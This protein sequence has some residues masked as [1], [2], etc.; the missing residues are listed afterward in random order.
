[1]KNNVIPLF[2]TPFGIYQLDVDL[3]RIYSSLSKFKTSP[4]Y[5][6]SGSKSSF[7]RDVSILYE[8]DFFH[9]FAKIQLA[10]EEYAKIVSL[11][12]I[13][14]T[15]SWYNEMSIGK[16]LISHRHEHSVV[17]GAFYIKCGKKTV[18]LKFRNPL[19]PY[20][21]MELYT[22]S[23]SDYSSGGMQFKPKPG[24]LFLFPSWLE[25]ETD[26]EKDDRCVISLNTTYKNEVQR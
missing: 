5:L 17:S 22:N 14:V 4:N 9:L 24:V 1:M 18:P 2:P 11:E 25:H 21:M 10:L 6:L 15:D 23:P 20:R 3:D 16:R 13:V 12:P 26:E 7:Q 19:T 8:D